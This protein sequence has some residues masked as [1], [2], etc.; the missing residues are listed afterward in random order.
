MHWRLMLE[1]V[2]T[3]NEVWSQV[4][5]ELVLL[6]WN[7]SRDDTVAEVEICYRGKT[8]F[9]R[10]LC[11]SRSHIMGDTELDMKLQG[12]QDNIGIAI[13][14]GGLGGLGLVTAET[15]VAEK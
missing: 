10:R 7:A 13:I 6:H 3:A 12:M 11:A 14:T 2:M 5:R 9:V 8:R 1:C 15:L 4:W